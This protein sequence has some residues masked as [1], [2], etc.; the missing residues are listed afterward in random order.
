[1][2]F[3]YFFML[4]CLLSL[5]NFYV[6]WLIMELIFLFFL[7]VVINK[8]LK[9]IGLIIYFFFQ[10]VRSLLL[11]VAVV[12][13]IHKLVFL[14][15]IAKLGVFPFF[16]WVVVV[17]VKLGIIGN[18]FVLSLQKV[19]VFWLIWLVG[20]VSFRFLYLLVYL[21]LFFV[22]VNLLLVVDFWLLLVYSS[23]ANRGL[24]IL[25]M[26]GSNYMFVVFLY[27]ITIIM[28]LYLL[29]FWILT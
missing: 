29:R 21:G 1:M 3:I 7:L 9:S 5:S 14:F 6:V 28:I 23:I 18:M 19:S 11:F 2:L 17:R 4:F 15:L 16:Y 22:V 10:S 8:E 12:F 13:F 27:L 26:Y 20:S 24:I 25:R